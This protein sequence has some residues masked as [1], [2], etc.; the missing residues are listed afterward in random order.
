MLMQKLSVVF[1]GIKGKS[2]K[3]VYTILALQIAISLF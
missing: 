1:L 3:S 2:Y